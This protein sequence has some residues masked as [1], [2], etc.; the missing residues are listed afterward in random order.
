MNYLFRILLVMFIFSN[1]TQSISQWHE[2]SKAGNYICYVKSSDRSPDI[3]SDWNKKFWN[4][5]EVV[6]LKN[7]MGDMPLHFPGT[8]VKLKYDDDNIYIIFRV[9]DNYVR[10]IAKETNGRVWEDSCVEFFFTPGP[11]VSRGYFNLEVNCKGVYLMQYHKNNGK[12]QGFVSLYDS[13]QIKISHS[14]QEDVENEIT[15]PFTWYIE[16]RI[17]YSILS[18]YIQVETPGPGIQWRANFYKCGDKTSHPHWLTWAPVNY[19]QPKFHLPE[20]FG[21]LEFK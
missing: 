12:E 11:D 10:A 9:K 18:K 16:Y 13:G 5:A 2:Q 20:Y 15:K 14:L 6:R 21:W 17:P 8:Q 4:K 19:P 1:Y 7:H 3:N